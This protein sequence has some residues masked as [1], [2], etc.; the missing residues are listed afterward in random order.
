MAEDKW[1]EECVLSGLQAL[2]ALK[3]I[4]SPASDQIKT[5]AEVWIAVLTDGQEWSRELDERRIKE[6]FKLLCKVSERWPA[7]RDFYRCLSPHRE[8]PKALPPPPI[9]EAERARRKAFIDEYAAKFA[10]PA[11]AQQ[12]EDDIEQRR[13]LAL[14]AIARANAAHAESWRG[15]A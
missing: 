9:D 4:A 8:M 12:Q 15:D 1:F 14:A 10:K 13:A 3:L 6:A 5:T 2:V 7:P 11:P